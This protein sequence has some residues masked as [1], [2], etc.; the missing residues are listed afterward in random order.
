MNA[1]IFKLLLQDI[2]DAEDI[3]DRQTAVYNYK[4]YCE[5]EAYRHNLVSQQEI[6]L[7]QRTRMREQTK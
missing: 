6:A 7:N 3:D 1:E 4:L 2:K 5:A